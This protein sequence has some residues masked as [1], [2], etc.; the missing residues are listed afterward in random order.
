MSIV[1][2][3]DCMFTQI[4]P[5]NAYLCAISVYIIVYLRARLASVIAYSCTISTQYA[6]QTELSESY[7]KYSYTHTYKYIYTYTK[8]TH[9][10]S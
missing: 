9:L 4:S 3:Y 1:S 8:Y 2:P 7:I 5:I 10:C 6:L